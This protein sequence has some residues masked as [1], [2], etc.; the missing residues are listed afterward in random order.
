MDI[1]FFI[2]AIF[3][4]KLSR[5]GQITTPIHQC[6]LN[7][8]QITTC[9]C[10]RYPCGD[11]YLVLLLCLSVVV[12]LWTQVIM[13]LVSSDLC[14]APSSLGNFTRDFTQHG[15]NFSLQVAYACFEGVFADDIAHGFVTDL[16]P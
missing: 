5:Q 14:S 16:Y 3:Y 13:D 6:G 11:S 12:F 2:E 7:S 4:A 8:C 15:C 9:A 10:P 1:V